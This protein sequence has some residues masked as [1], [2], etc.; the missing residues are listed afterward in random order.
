MAVQI[1][2]N[3]GQEMK[4]SIPE[5]SQTLYLDTVDVTERVVHTR[6]CPHLMRR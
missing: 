4:I 3:E 1:G 2:A 5:V 6:Q